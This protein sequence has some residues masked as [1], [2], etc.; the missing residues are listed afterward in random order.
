M[1]YHGNARLVKHFLKINVIC[2]IRRLK[3]KHSMTISID[4]ENEF[5]EI[6]DCS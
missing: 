6:Q 5:D 3:N 2:S 1:V 4:T